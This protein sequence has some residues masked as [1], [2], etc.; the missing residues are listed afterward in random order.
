MAQPPHTCATCL[1]EAADNGLQQVRRR[2]TASGD[3]WSD[4]VN[5]GGVPIFLTR[6][7]RL[8]DWPLRRLFGWAAWILAAVQSFV[9][10]PLGSYKHQQQ[11]SALAVAYQ[12]RRVLSRQ[13]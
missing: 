1:S 5:S 11:L 4:W 10:R 6:I 2:P 3:I 12:R 7:R 9:D 13:E 8:A